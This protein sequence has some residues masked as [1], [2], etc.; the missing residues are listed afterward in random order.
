MPN[1]GSGLGGQVG[2]A[3]E[4]IYGTYVAPSKFIEVDKV[5]L[6]KVKNTVQGGGL[7][8]GRAARLG[9][10]RAVTTQGAEGSIEMEVTNKLMGVLFQ[11]L[12]GT[13][14]TP[15]QQGATAAYLQTHDLNVASFGKSLS[16]Q[17][18]VPL[19]S[20]VTSAF[21][22]LGCKITKAEF[23]CEVDGTLQ[24]T[25]DVD[26][27]KL[28]EGQTLGTASYTTTIAPFHWGQSAIKIHNTYGSE[29]AVDGVKEFT[30]TI[31]RKMDTERFYIGNG[32]LK[33]EPITNEWLEVSGSFTVD[34]LAKADFNDRFS[35]DT[36]F[37]IVW[38]FVGPLIASTFYET[39][40]FRLPLNFLD[41]DTP[42]LDGPDIVS[43][44]FPFVT[45]LDGTRALATIEYIS[46]EAAL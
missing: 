12:M 20:A 15:V 22:Y 8:A 3:V 41:G 4:S 14:V 7:A 16:I 5:D 32:G 2:I 24:V 29:V 43:G 37:S 25:F 9:S 19:T 17:V 28:D 38:E 13:T 31:E 23:K 36:G 33:S 39:V 26:G 27:R 18:G 21:S 10:R 1:V 46:A 30:L 11:A 42:G 6:K 40:R 35:A 44:E 34:Y 45:Q